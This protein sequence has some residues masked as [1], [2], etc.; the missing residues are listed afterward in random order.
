MEFLVVIKL[1]GGSDKDL[2]C[3]DGPSVAGN[4]DDIKEIKSDP[5]SPNI[6]NP[7]SE[8]KS[9]SKTDEDSNGTDSKVNIIF[10]QN[11]Y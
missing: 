4:D 11:S 5:K 9:E 6:E 2:K 1:E 8:S 10:I 3:L 7:D